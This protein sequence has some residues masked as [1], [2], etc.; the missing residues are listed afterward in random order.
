M[1]KCYLNIKSLLATDCPPLLPLRG[2]ELN[3]L[4]RI[5]NAYLIV[6]DGRISDYGPMSQLPRL[7]DYCVS[8]DVR[9]KWIIPAFVDSH[10]HIIYS[11]SR[12]QEMADK[13]AGLSYVEIA[14]RG[15]GILNSAQRL[16]NTSE[17][18]LY[19]TAMQRLQQCITGGTGAIEIKSGYGLNTADELKMLRVARRIGANAPITVKTT[20][21]AAHAF[22]PEYAHDHDGYV[23]LITD[24]MIPR[25]ADEGLAD[26]IDVFCDEGFFSVKHTEIILE[27][28]AKYNIHPKIHANELALSGG[29]QVGVKH[30]ALSVDHLEHL[31]KEE[32]DLL[33]QHPT[34]ATLL[35]GAAFFLG[36][37]YAPAR[38]LIEGGAAVALASDFNPG[39][40]PSGSMKFVISLACIAMRMTPEEAIN[41]ATVNGAFAMGLSQTHGCI[42]RGRAAN[43]IITQPMESL[44][45]IP[46]AYTEPLIDEVV[47][48]KADK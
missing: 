1:M 9:G 46:Y 35:P 40:S 38:Q 28:A 45:Y 42:S 16:H 10:T 6:E 41:A 32:I 23:R 31:G 48:S 12:E 21:L 15:G 43:F 22:P 33:A 36:M 30:K 8:K 18:E 3:M 13:I 27:T 17:S 5:D 44:A 2:N 29:V 26:F 47:T 4:H 19:D 34:I 24:E 14:R 20:L 11:G 37:N 7:P 39:S 25:A